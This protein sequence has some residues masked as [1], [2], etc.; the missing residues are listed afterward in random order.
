M[1]LRDSEGLFV[2]F[3]E[4]GNFQPHKV[5]LFY[6]DHTDAIAVIMMVI[7]SAEK[8]EHPR[9]LYLVLLS[10]QW[11]I[12]YDLTFEKV[13]KENVIP[14]AWE[15]NNC[16]KRFEKRRTEWEPVLKI[17]FSRAICEER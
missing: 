12:D 3:H 15:K 13:L 11:F 10:C 1:N 7:S 17:I 4:R 2:S 16:K 8:W 6:R 5:A 9:R 14:M